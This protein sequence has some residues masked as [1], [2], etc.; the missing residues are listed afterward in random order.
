MQPTV[1]STR[2]GHRAV[3]FLVLM[4]LAQ[5]CGGGSNQSTGPTTSTEVVIPLTGIT[6]AQFPANCTGQ[7]TATGPGRAQTASLPPFDNV[8]LSLGAG[9]WTLTATI[10]CGG[11]TARGSTTVM[12]VPPN[13]INVSIRV[14]VRGTLTVTTD[15]P[16]SVAVSP[17]G[18]S[19]GA[20]C[21]SYFIG[22][23][24]TLTATPGSGATFT[25]WSGGGCSGTGGCRV[26]I[27]TTPTA[28]TATFSPGP[29]P[30]VPSN[31][32]VTI[33]GSGTVAS[34]PP[35]IGCPPTCTAPFPNG[36]TVT[37]TA[38]PTGGS[39]FGGWSVPACGRSLTCA[40]PI[41]GPTTVT[42][43]FAGPVT[44]TVVKAGS[45]TG[46]VTGGGINCG[47]TCSVTVPPGTVITLTA[48][49]T[50]GST[51]GG[52]SLPACPG[53]SLTC[54]VP[55]TGSTTV[56]ATFNKG[57][58]TLTV[59]KAGSG[60]GTVTGEGINCGATCSVTVPPGTVITLT[61]TPTGG[62]TFGGW[63]VVGGPACPGTG[64]CAVT[65][66]G[67][68]TVTATFTPAVTLT[69]AF[70]QGGGTGT[71]T[72][73]LGGI[74]CPGTCMA[75]FPSGTTVT[76]TASPTG[77]STFGSW[78]VVSGPACPGT[79]P[80]TVTM[81]GN[82]TVTATFIPPQPTTVSLTVSINNT[83]GDGTVT[84]NPGGI[85][86][87][88]TC[89]GSFQP[90]T[91][92]TLTAIPT[93]TPSSGSTF[94][95]W[96][97][98]GGPACPGIGLCTVTMTGN[99]TVTATFGCCAIPRRFRSG[100][101]VWSEVAVPQLPTATLRLLAP[102]LFGARLAGLKSLAF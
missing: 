65:M 76:L 99:I 52:W 48:T 63:S 45:G 84:S 49:P 29:T 88:G 20:N 25:G 62:S 93:V 102:P 30:P 53:T 33:V 70:G 11:Q 27:G 28:V 92:V 58:V 64:P 97:V 8:T 16:G 4:A 6:A 5:A 15:G 87:P 77:G 35:G 85:N 14:N 21:H 26:T 37:L 98:V 36:T 67:N 100:S 41:T 57:P 82:I 19:C 46:T 24:V 94:S 69:V 51:F 75:L 56:T 50:G 101:E 47:A 91:I 74:N 68:I 18:D 71:V 60:T 34:V 44:L 22:T 40:V 81:T 23:P 1:S 32:S 13:P 89:I 72:S 80:C 10:T 96:S 9:L 55:I 31:L 78:S 79:G 83:D 66:T 17:A 42:A 7:L 73:N 95:G 43:T 2:F 3:W 90:G 54:A 38:T 61:A 86:C 59:V 12:V 39:T